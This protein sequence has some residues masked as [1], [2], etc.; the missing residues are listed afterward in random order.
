MNRKWFT[1]TR[2]AVYGSLLFIIAVFSV[3][4][5]TKEIIATANQ[6]LKMTDSLMFVQWH[7]PCDKV[8]IDKDRQLDITFMKVECKLDQLLSER[9][10]MRAREQFE[11]DSIRYLR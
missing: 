9:M 1:K 7:A 8:R 3:L 2:I 6:K 4:A 5:G 10:K 11:R